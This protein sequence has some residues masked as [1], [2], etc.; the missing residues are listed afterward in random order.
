[1]QNTIVYLI[2]TGVGKRDEITDRQTHFGLQ[3]IRKG[4]SKLLETKQNLWHRCVIEY[5]GERSKWS[6]PVQESAL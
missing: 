3:G 1:M 6:P 5:K 4:D 2:D